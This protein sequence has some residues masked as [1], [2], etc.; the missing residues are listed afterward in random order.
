MNDAFTDWR[1]ASYS[2]ASGNCIEVAVSWRKSSHSEANGN[3]IEVASRDWRKSSHSAANG[4]CVEIAGAEPV[5]GV[6]DTKQHEVGPVLEFSGAAWQAF[7]ADVKSG[8]AWLL[9][10]GRDQIVTS[11][12]LRVAHAYAGMRDPLPFRAI[13]QMGLHSSLCRPILRTFLD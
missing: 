6:R 4:G 12:C 10:P 8:A 2:G 11:A 1:S 5:V 9:A 3:C 13:A 7:L